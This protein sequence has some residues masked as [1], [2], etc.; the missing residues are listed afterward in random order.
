[1]LLNCTPLPNSNCSP[2]LPNR[3]PLCS[4]IV[5]PY[6]SPSHRQCQNRIWFYSLY[7][8]FSISIWSKYMPFIAA[9]DISTIA[10]SARSLSSFSNTCSIRYLCLHF[11][12]P[13][14]ILMLPSFS[15]AICCSFQC[16]TNQ[17]FRISTG[18]VRDIKKRV[19]TSNSTYFSPK[20][21]K[22]LGS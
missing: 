5:H 13:S 3:A 6:A 8:W 18:T 19:I 14:S 16:V 20:H 11:V 1:M 12:A 4:P 9:M 17:F 7:P 15:A 2:M 10:H 21:I 22:I